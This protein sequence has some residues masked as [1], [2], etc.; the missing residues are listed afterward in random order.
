MKNNLKG[1][2][3]AQTKNSK[4]LSAISCCLNVKERK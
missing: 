3:E 1:K 4:I 2:L